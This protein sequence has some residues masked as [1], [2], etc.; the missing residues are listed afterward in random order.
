M[1]KAWRQQNTRLDFNCYE[2]TLNSSSNPFTN[3]DILQEEFSQET[4]KI[5]VDRFTIAVYI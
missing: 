5:R 4:A 1:Q 2:T 3:P